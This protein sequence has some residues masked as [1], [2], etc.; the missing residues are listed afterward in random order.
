MI[1]FWYWLILGVA[2]MAAEIVAPGVFLLWL[3]V[4]ALITGGLTYFAPD[5]SWQIQLAIFAV[6]SIA[7][8]VGA[9][10]W[11]RGR[12][13]ET[14]R[15]SLNL[16]GNRYIGRVVELEGPI[17][18]G[19]GRARVGDSIWPVSGPDLPAGSAV[20]VIDVNGTVLKVEPVET[21]TADAASR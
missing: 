20:R 15:P 5:L 8:L 17:H 10:R 3:G 21:P 7:A 4:A 9:W 13:I 11:V 1:E 19:R 14:D 6:L 2:L 18:N 12:P 16:R